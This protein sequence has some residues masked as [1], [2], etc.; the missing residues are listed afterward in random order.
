MDTYVYCTKLCVGKIS[1]SIKHLSDKR[2]ILIELNY[3]QKV[4]IFFFSKV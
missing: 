1:V 3:E 2:M 4:I